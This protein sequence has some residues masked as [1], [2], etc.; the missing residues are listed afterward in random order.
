MKVDLGYDTGI[1]T[2]GYS[3]TNPGLGILTPWS[4]NPFYTDALIQ[5]F[6]RAGEQAVMICL[7]HTLKPVGLP[8]IALAA[9]FFH[10][11]TSAPAAGAP[12]VESE[13]D[14]HVDWRPEHRPLEGLWFRVQYGRSTVWQGGTVTSSEE[15]R[16]VLN[17]DLKIY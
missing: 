7:S 6:Q 17:Y 12:L 8:G 13:W 4:A 1:L 14:F 10:G 11:W 5:G 9:H 3:V 16:V 2:L 15:L